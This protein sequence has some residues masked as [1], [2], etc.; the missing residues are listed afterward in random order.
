[1]RKMSPPQK[2][3]GFDSK[4]SKHRANVRKKIKAGKMPKFVDAWRSIEF[5][6]VLTIA[7]HGNCAFCE[8]K[9]HGAQNGDV[10][11]FFPKSQLS[12]LGADPKTWGKELPGVTSVAGRKTNRL[13]RQGYWW[14]AYEWENYLLS[15]LVCNSKWKRTIFPVKE[16]HRKLPP[17]SR[18]RETPL[19]LSP[20]RGPS[21]YTHLLFDSTGMVSANS[22]SP[23]GRETIKTCGLN[24][25]SLSSSRKGIF[26]TLLCQL[27]DFRKCKGNTEIYKRSIRTMFQL[28]QPDRAH[29]GMVRNV[30]ARE[31]G[32]K[33]PE[34]ERLYQKFW[35]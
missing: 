8:M 27:E 33:W 29:S 20:F 31:L 14:K 2:P 9:V 22:G 30:I 11:H 28:G 17:S 34:L 4:V 25:E 16:T 12:E 3:T 7:Q 18:T 15:C 13:S 32:V 24:R 26:C 1:M 23:F 35:P 21:P 5:K 6:R 19:L 10:E